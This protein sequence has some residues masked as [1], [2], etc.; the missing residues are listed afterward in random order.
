MLLKAGSEGYLQRVYRKNSDG[1]WIF[2]RYKLYE[3]RVNDVC[4]T[5]IPIQQFYCQFSPHIKYYEI[6]KNYAKINP[7]KSN[8][9]LIL[10]IHIYS[11][12]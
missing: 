8:E 10:K 5:D 11:D 12:L 2:S 7:L 3:R 4:E 9:R 1:L 6:L